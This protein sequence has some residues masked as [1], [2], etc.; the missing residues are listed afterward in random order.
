MVERVNC[1]EFIR[2]LIAEGFTW[3]LHQKGPAFQPEPQELFKNSFYPRR[4]K[5]VT[6]TAL[7]S[8]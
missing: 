3:S 2:V 4:V 5:L 7:T 1:F 6:P 8:P